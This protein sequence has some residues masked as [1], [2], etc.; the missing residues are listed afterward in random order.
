MERFFDFGMNLATG[1][2][3]AIAGGI[4]WLIRRVLTNQT[5]IALLKQHIAKQEEQLE[6]VSESVTRIEGWIMEKAK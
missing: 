5:E 6:R 2:V 3:T 1:I 4:V